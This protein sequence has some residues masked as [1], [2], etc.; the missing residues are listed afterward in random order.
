MSES[1][2]A[3][4]L[5]LEPNKINWCSFTLSCNSLLNLFTIFKS[6]ASIAFPLHF[7]MHHSLISQRWFSAITV[8]K[9]R[10]AH[11]VNFLL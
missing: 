1:G 2:S 7:C 9:M 3:S 8:S 4:P 5:A 6:L 10:G 11:V